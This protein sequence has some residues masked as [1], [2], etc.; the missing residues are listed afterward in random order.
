LVVVLRGC[1]VQDVARDVISTSATNPRN[2]AESLVNIIWA[3]YSIR[4]NEAVPV[5]YNS[6]MI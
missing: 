3:S 2:I 5:W 4:S 6:H 1:V